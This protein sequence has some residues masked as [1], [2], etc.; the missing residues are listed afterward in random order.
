METC[1]KAFSSSLIDDL[2]LKSDGFD[3]EPEITT[4]FLKKKHKILEIPIKYDPRNAKSGKKI[5]F[6]DGLAA[7]YSLFKFRFSK[8]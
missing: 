7:I 3:I 4:K 1:Y 5:K 8:Y 2:N 6:K